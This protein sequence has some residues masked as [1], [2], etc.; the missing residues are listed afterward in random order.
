MAEFLDQEPDIEAGMVRQTPLGR[1]ATPEDA[2]QAAAWL[3]SD[4]SSYVAG[5]VLPLDG[6]L[7]A[8]RA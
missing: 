4:R 7:T 1:L 5:V 6:G 2:A 8:V 3:L